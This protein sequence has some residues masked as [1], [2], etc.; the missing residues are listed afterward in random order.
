MFKAHILKLFSVF[1]GIL[2]TL[3]M[4]I[5]YGCVPFYKY[6][7]KLRYILLGAENSKK[8]ILTHDDLSSHMTTS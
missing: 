1:H 2:N 3:S 5:S 7:N 4:K 6:V 8:I